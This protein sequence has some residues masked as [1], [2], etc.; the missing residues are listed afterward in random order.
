MRRIFLTLRLAIISCITLTQFSA[1]A[2]Q[3][4]INVTFSGSQEVP[5][6][7]SAGTGTFVGT[8]NDV[9]DSLIY[10]VTFSGLSANVTGAHFHAG[11]PGIAAPIYIVPSGIPFPT[12]VMS[13]TFTDTLVLTQGQED[14]LKMGL[15]YFNIHTTA[16]QSGEIRAQIFLKDASFVIPDVICP[17]DTT[18]NNTPGICSA[19]VAFGADTNTAVPTAVLYYRIGNTAITSPYVFPVGTT[20]VVA[21]ALNAAGYDSCTF[22]VTVEDVEPPVVTCPANITKPNDPGKCGAVVTYP[23]ATASDNCSTV[24]ITYSKASGSFFDVGTTTVTVTA[25]DGSNNTATCSFTVTVNDVEPPV[26]HDLTAFPPILWPPNHKMKDVDVDYTSTDNCPGPITCNVTVTSD[27]PENGTG[28]GDLSP[29]WQTIDDH[30]IKLRAERA[31][32]GDGRTYTITVSCTDQHGN[33]GTATTTVL[34]PHDM[35]SREIRQLVFQYWAHGHKHGNTLGE[36][37]EEMPAGQGRSVVIVNGDDI[38]MSTLIRVYP[39]PS[40]NYFTMNIQTNNKEKI[41][42]RLI[43]MMGRVVEVRNN[44]SGTQSLKM[45]NNL[46]SGIYVAEIKQGEETQQVKLVKQ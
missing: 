5:P 34:V 32:T 3:Y 18:V 38:E 41:S 15:L 39:N 31:G 4:P 13:G 40:T 11:P 35:R 46:R 12:G 36:T 14:T 25:T 30:N 23:D 44:L 45:G 9:T 20:T 2:T 21:T 37:W 24:T 26:I 43:D 16:I 7:S 33:T 42:V 28:D 1:N 29:D 27:E 8:Y 19:S 17:N 10:T 6:N 22:K